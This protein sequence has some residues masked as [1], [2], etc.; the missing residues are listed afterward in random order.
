MKP[1]KNSWWKIFL[2]TQLLIPIIG[3]I[4]WFLNANYMYMCT[5]PIAEN[6]LLFG[7]WPWYFI[8]MEIAALLHFFMIY[9]PFI[10][11]YKNKI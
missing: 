11:K 1:R 8:G 7:E 10:S 9:V 6:P 2:W 3:T 5:K 4:N